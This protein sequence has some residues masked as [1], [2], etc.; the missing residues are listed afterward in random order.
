VISAILCFTMGIFLQTI[1]FLL[2]WF[3]FITGLVLGIVGLL[4]MIRRNK[5]KN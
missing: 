5:K 1:N 3:L 2:S 4:L